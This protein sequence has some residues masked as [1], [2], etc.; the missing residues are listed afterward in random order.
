MYTLSEG[1]DHLQVNS[2]SHGTSNSHGNSHSLKTVLRTESFP[3]DKP[4]VCI[5]FLRDGII[6]MRLDAYMYIHTVSRT[7]L[8]I[9]RILLIH[10]WDMTHLYVGHDAFIRDFT[11]ICTCTLFE[12]FFLFLSLIHTHTYTHIHTHKHTHSLFHTHT[13]A[14]MRAHTHTHT[15]AHSHTHALSL[16]L[17]LS[18]SHTHTHIHTLTHSHTH[19]HIHL[20][21]TLI[22]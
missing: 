18:L 4:R 13:H 14:Q 9:C 11:L 2:N 22:H 17:S 3:C 20:R 19:T 6:H 15:Q 1:W 21:Q 7:Q 5:H 12:F 8:F 10:T 16:F